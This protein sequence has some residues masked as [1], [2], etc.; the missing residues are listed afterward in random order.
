MREYSEQELKEL[1]GVLFEILEE[2]IRVCEVLKIEYTAI[3]GTAIGAY[4]WQD[5]IPWDDDMDI[6]MTRKN[7]DRFLREAPAVLKTEFFLAWYGT[8]PESPFFFAKLRK[9][10]TLFV[11]EQCRKLDMNHGIYVD[12][13]P[14]DNMPKS[15]LAEVLQRK[16]VNRLNEC[17]AGKSVWTWRYF[18]KCEIEKP[19][20]KG[21]FNCLF[22][23]MVVTLVPKGT[24]YRMLYRLLTLYDNKEADTVN[25]I[26][27]SVDQI[28]AID[29]RNSRKMKLGPTEVTVPDH[30]PEY[31]H[32][33][34][35]PGLKKIPPKEMQVNHA[36][37]TLSFGEKSKAQD[38]L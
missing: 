30:L 16:A 20:A 19:H 27:T 21:F 37:L 12:I 17:F 35:G 32:H 34:Y 29:L 36:P 9:R 4:Y 15:K 31:L 25:I 3:G 5:I 23:R 14:L 24:I 28:P 22:T 38:R 2:I 10:G 18:G 33:H 1:H 11:E 13:F 7:Y 8:D 26:T 6:G